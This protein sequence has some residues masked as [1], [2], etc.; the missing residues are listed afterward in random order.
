MSLEYRV[1]VPL[2]A[3]VGQ[4]P[5][6]VRGPLRELAF[7]AHLLVYHSTLGWRVIQKK[8]KDPLRA[9]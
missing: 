1:R 7:K 4:L 2:V 5:Q 8:K 6:R 9:R 3:G